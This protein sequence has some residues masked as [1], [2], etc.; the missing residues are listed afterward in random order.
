M[1]DV[2]VNETNWTEAENFHCPKCNAYLTYTA[3]HKIRAFDGFTQFDPVRISVE[4][5]GSRLERRPL[6]DDL[7]R[8]AEAT[9]R[10][11]AYWY[12]DNLVQDG[13]KLSEPRNA[14]GLERVSQFYTTRNLHALASI[15]HEIRTSHD[16]K[17]R[18]VFTATLRRVTKMNR[19]MA[20]HKL[21]RSR[22]LVGPLDKTAHIPAIYFEANP[23]LYFQ[24]KAEEY[25]RLSLPAGS[26]ARFDP[27]C[28]RSPQCSESKHGLYLC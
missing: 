10:P 19:Y 22:E 27:I 18:A 4:L 8:I 20:K 7:R 16:H 6:P 13:E 25:A 2:T 12:P 26:L 24:A 14:H 3:C 15:W 23:L 17:L 28:N 1:W 11:I 21:N 5:G 9:E